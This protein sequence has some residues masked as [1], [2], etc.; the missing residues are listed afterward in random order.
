M[1]MINCVPNYVCECQEYF[2]ADSAFSDGVVQCL[3]CAAASGECECDQLAYAGICQLCDMRQTWK[4]E[5]DAE[6]AQAELTPMI[7]AVKLKITQ[8]KHDLATA[9]LPGT[10][11]HEYLRRKLEMRLEPCLSALE[12]VEEKSVWATSVIREV[13]EVLRIEDYQEGRPYCGLNGCTCHL[14]RLNEL[15]QE[16]MSPEMKALNEKIAATTAERHLRREI[17]E[18][19]W[20]ALDK[21]R[22]QKRIADEMVCEH[23]CETD[24]STEDYDEELE[25]LHRALQLKRDEQDAAEAAYAAAL[26][27]ANESWA[28]F[29]LL[30]SQV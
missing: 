9:T 15:E 5:H 27:S 2:D 6:K 17:V 20:D 19:C 14:S 21:V 24:I 22:F 18:K 1:S 30:M 26:A 23:E 11:S 13:K 12:M 4:E 25:K 8:H 29:R 7:S 16:K 3:P 10:Y 28:K